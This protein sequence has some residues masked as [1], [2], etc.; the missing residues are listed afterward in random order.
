MK[1]AMSLLLVMCLLSGCVNNGYKTVEESMLHGEIKYKQI[2]YKHEVKN[3]IIVF[4]EDPYGGLDAGIVYKN[5]SGYNW[6][7]GG[8]TAEIPTPET[9]V[10]WNWVNLDNNAKR[11]DRQ[12]QLYFGLI[13]GQSI[14]R[15]HIEH[16][17]KIKYIDKDAELVDLPDGNKL[18][19][20]LQDEYSEYH[21]GFILNGFNKNGENIVHF[22]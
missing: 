11:E 22:E 14:T 8:G 13:K 9:E 7:F 16:K 6:G 1:N 17:G 3:G 19:F 20:A 12:Y 2:Y 18:W 10:S 5:N 4:Y 21:P 15:L